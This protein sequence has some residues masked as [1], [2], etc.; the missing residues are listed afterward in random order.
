MLTQRDV[1]KMTVTE[2]LATI[3][4]LWTNL[5]ATQADIRPP[6]WHR[7]VLAVREADYAAGKE[8]SLDWTVAKAS[9]LHEVSCA[10]RS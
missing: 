4:L 7:D 2:K 6:A 10:S 1:E 9:I 8:K 5:L 3:E